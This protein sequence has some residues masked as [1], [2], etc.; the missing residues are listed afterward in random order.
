MIKIERGLM[1]NQGTVHK[2]RIKLRSW[3]NNAN[4]CEKYLSG[5]RFNVKIIYMKHFSLMYIYVICPLEITLL[6][7]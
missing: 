1:I 3:L 5:D 2:N 6:V 7:A 4:T